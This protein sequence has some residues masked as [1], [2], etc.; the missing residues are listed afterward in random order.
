MSSSQSCASVCN[1][2]K[3]CCFMIKFTPEDIFYQKESTFDVFHPNVG[4]SS[5]FHTGILMKNG[6]WMSKTLG[7]TVEI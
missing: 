5:P 2:G 6:I 1:V 7:K 3:T 4:P